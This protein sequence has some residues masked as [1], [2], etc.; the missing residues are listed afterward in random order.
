MKVLIALPVPD[1][2]EVM[3]LA[4]D[5]RGVTAAVARHGDDVT[6]LATQ[7][8]IE[9]VLLDPAVEGFDKLAGLRTLRAAV[10]PMPIMV[11]SPKGKV[12]EKVAAL[13]AGADDYQVTP[14]HFDEIIAR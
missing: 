2:A 12:A 10:G 4:F 11:L 14:I 1:V 6:F 7:G 9:A 3:S 8:G 13:T 5:I